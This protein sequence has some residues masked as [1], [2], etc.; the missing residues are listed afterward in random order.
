VGHYKS[1][2]RVRQRNPGEPKL[3]HCLSLA[4]LSPQSLNQFAGIMS[5]AEALSSEIALIYKGL[6]CSTP[7]GL[8]SPPPAKKRRSR[9]NTENIVTTRA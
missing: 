4:S 7:V 1:H 2:R 5:K 8:N 9:R 3:S 6:A